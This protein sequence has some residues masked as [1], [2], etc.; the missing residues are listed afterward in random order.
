MVNNYEIISSQIIPKT[1]VLELI[2]EKSKKNELTYRE[3]KI[4]DF[5]KKRVKLNSKK[6]EEAKNELL[7]LELARLDEEHIIKILEIMP[8]S[9]VELRALVSH[10]GTIIIDDSVKKIL[11]ILKKYQ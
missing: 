9:G 3:E 5:L 4:Q 1:N 2:E 11:D 7:A 10:S 6:F 8:K